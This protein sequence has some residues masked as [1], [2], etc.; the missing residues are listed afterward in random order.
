MAE[1]DLGATAAAVRRFDPDLFATALFAPEPARAWLMTLYAF[2]I[3]LSRAAQRASRAEEG[4]MIAAMR[5]QW[6]RDQIAAAVEGAGPPA[7]EIAGPLARLIGDGRLVRGDLEGM[8][9]ARETEVAG[10]VADTGL[11]DWAD[12]RFGALTRL[13]A[14]LLDA[15]APAA[16]APA[17][18]ALG[19]G[20][21]L[22]TA[23][24]MA[25]HGEA[26]LPELSGAPLGPLGRGEL[27]AATARALAARA[28]EGLEAVRAARAA[29]APRAAVPAFLPLWRAERTLARVAARPERVATE[30]GPAPE[31]PARRVLALGWRALTG[32]W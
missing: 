1:P 18:Q 21:A 10:E 4:P 7:H 3:E 22:R 29:G 19:L 14:G 32:R 31:A 20:F 13:A 8:I 6:W 9:A 17:G 24:A 26:L 28:R 25:R 2:D 23:R 27:D 5:L 15:P 11:P 12:E 16:A 30:A